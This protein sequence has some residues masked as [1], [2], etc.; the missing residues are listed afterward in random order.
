M[1]IKSVVIFLFTIFLLSCR[2]SHRNDNGLTVFRYNEAAG[3]SSL[4]PAF[5]RNQANIWAVNQIFNGLVQLD[6]ALH[7]IPSIASKWEISEDGRTYTFYLRDDVYFHD[8][9]VFS[10]GRGRKLT[11]ADVVYS[12]KRLADERLAS[13]GAWVMS[14][15]EGK[16]INKKIDA[17]GDSIVTIRLKQPFPPFLGMLSMQYCSIVPFEAIEFYGQDF[18]VHPVGTGP[19]RFK[20]LKEGVKLVMVKNPNYFETDSSGAKFPYLDAIAVTFIIDKQSAFLEFVKGNLDFMSGLDAS[21]KDEVLTATGK[22]KSKYADKINLAT[23]PYLNTE[24]LGIL[25]DSKNLIMKDSP[26]N[27]VRIRKAI[28]MGFDRDKMI[29]YLRNGIGKPGIK[30]I[31]PDGLPGYSDDAQYGYKYDPE[32]A[33]QLL[34]EAG[35]PNGKGLP[36]ITFSTNASYLDITQFIQSQL[37]QIGINVRI[38]VSPPGTLRENIAQGR[39]PFFRGSWIADY[40][41]AENYLSLFYSINK[42][43]NGP[44]YTHFNDKVF[45]GLYKEAILQTNDTLR[46]RLYREMDSLMMQQSPVVILFY[47]Q[48]LRFSQKTISGLGSNALNLLDLKRVKKRIIENEKGNFKNHK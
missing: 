26:L 48:V 21:Y 47:D 22:L 24:Y 32:R 44:N 25:S 28:N 2:N 23:Q 45:D 11:A 13:P 41:D 42:S 27:D 15:V 38:D 20:M 7:V 14:N 12:L 16:G 19:F 5:A 37:S 31:I 29:R 30:G 9:P 33:A 39:V 3:I 8:S 46:V 36:P 17:I 43:P 1:R 40:P 10:N 6:S 4:D 35:Y 18:R 34:K